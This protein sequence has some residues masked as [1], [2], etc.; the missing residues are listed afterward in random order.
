MSQDEIKKEDKFDNMIKA[1]KSRE[2]MSNY[3]RVL[4][5]VN[6]NGIPKKVDDS[7]RADSFRMKKNSNGSKK[8]EFLGFSVIVSMEIMGKREVSGRE[9]Y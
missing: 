6:T 5:E 3:S 8:F 9:G 7:A 2:A 4:W 1:I